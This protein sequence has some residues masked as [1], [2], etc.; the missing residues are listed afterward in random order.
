MRVWPASMGDW[1]GV[2]ARMRERIG[3]YFRYRLT[4]LSMNVPH[5]EQ[6]GMTGG[7][8]HRGGAM[9]HCCHGHYRDGIFS[10]FVYGFLKLL[11]LLIVISFIASFFGM[12]GWGMPWHTG[13]YGM[14]GGMMDRWSV[15]KDS[16]RVFGV[17]QKIDGA[18]ITILDNGNAERAIVST[19]STI[20]TDGD[21]ELS[22]GDLK[23]GERIGVTGKSDDKALTA[24]LIE[25]ISL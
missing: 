21:T 16:S 22:I 10:F 2:S 24:K 11:I 1:C 6:D 8:M 3:V 7:G 5:G 14:P 20:I 23:V 25:V 17:I 9:G 12:R 19:A 4:S 18:T 15:D 13:G